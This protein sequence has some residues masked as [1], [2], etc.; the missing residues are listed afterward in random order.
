MAALFSANQTTVSQHVQRDNGRVKLL[1]RLFFDPTDNGL[2]LSWGSESP[3]QFTR[4]CEHFDL[5]NF[6]HFQWKLETG[7]ALIQRDEKYFAL[8]NITRFGKYNG[9]PAKQ[10]APNRDSCIPFPIVL[11]HFAKKNA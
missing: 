10:Q 2:T 11:R 9:T 5:A 6:A 8:K 4:R 3:Q 1:K 7:R